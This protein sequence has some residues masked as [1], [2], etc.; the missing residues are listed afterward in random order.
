MNASE[1]DPATVCVGAF[2]TLETGAYLDVALLVQGPSSSEPISSDQ[3]EDN[4]A[5]TGADSEGQRYGMSGGNAKAAV[6]MSEWVRTD[7]YGWTKV[8]GTDYSISL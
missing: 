2:S 3:S 7:D 1:V 8:K 6:V 5:E 4:G